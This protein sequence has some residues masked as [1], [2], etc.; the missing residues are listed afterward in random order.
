MAGYVVIGDDMQEIALAGQW[1]ASISREEKEPIGE[2]KA[3]R[4]CV[5]AAKQRTV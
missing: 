4:W 5:D 3:R 1:D 2:Q